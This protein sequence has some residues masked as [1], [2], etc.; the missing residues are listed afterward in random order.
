MPDSED[1]E[2][3]LAAVRRS[4]HRAMDR[5]VEAVY[6]E[7]KRLARFQ[8][9]GERPGHTL[10]TTAIVHEA[11]LRIAAGNTRWTDRRHFLRAATTVIRHLLVDHAR[12]RN[13]GKRGGGVAP[14]ALADEGLPTEDD[15][16]AVIALDGALKGMAALD[17]R[18]EQIVEC[19]C[20]AGLSVS[21]TADALGMSVRTVEREWQRAKGYLL[22]ALDR[23]NP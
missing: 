14:I 23:E 8:L 17:P 15:S 10:T 16:V 1:I 13:A 11:Y 9:A 6:P 21:D 12:Q 5:L 4:D 7:L 3:L 20:F 18:L 22:R 19:R 2:E